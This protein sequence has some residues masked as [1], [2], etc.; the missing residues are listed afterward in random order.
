MIS[1]NPSLGFIAHSIEN[2]DKRKYNRK[3]GNTSRLK[4]L[5]SG[6]IVLG[7]N[8]FTNT[9]IKTI[10]PN[11]NNL[12]DKVLSNTFVEYIK[13]KIIIVDTNKKYNSKYLNSLF[14]F[15]LDLFFAIS[16]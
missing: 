11:P 8:S 7:L 15:R 16:N 13:G 5:K 2:A 6:I 3:V 10:T 9:R 4:K 12:G 1:N 14:C